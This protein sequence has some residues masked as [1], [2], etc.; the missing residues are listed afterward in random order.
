MDRV[1]KNKTAIFVFVFPA[2]A[3]F[4][5]VVILSIVY[6]GYYSLHNW[7]GIGEKVFIGFEN[8]VKMFTGPDSGVFIKSIA[9]TFIL[10]ILTVLIQLPLA[11]ILALILT[12][13]IKGENFLRT[14]FFVPVVLSAVIIALL[15]RQL[16]HPTLGL[17][18]T[19][20]KGIG[21]ESLTRIWLGDTK[22]AL[23]AVM[24]PIIWQ[25]IGYQMLL[26]YA[27]IKTIP[28]DIKEAAY[29]DGAT[30][31][32]TALKITI[33]LIK[34]VLKVCVIFAVIGSLQ[35]FDMVYVLTNGGPSHASEVPST[36]MY[37]T[38]FHKNQYG[39]GSA[40]SMF[41]VAEC[42]LISRL[43]QKLFKTDNITY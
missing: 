28:Q 32:H 21:L 14:V 13:G 31:I 43:I 4:C 17:L 29:I 5:G 34:P 7:N 33:P 19:V 42:V 37:Q 16:Y 23:G 35:A 6:S 41:I 8:Y 27:S 9:N 22:T 12:S 25:W 1:F 11:M 36:L 18:N 3:I 20:L 24:A 39:F 26:M 38:F 10:A 40:L 2:F 15:F 30:G